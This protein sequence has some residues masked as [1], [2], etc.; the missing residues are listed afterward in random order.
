MSL[1]G[2]EYGNPHGMSTSLERVFGQ[3]LPCEKA[4]SVAIMNEKLVH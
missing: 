3:Q 1:H 4:K 2:A